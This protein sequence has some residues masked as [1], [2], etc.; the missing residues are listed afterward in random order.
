M[1]ELE[2]LSE[3]QRHMNK[4]DFGMYCQNETRLYIGD[5][6]YFIS[7]EILV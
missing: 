1:F 3:I 2:I 5:L 4:R 6:L 7:I